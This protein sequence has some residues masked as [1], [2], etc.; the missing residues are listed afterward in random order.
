[1]IKE[2]SPH[3]GFESTNLITGWIQH[4]PGFAQVAIL[5]KHL[6]VRNNLNKT[7]TGGLSSYALLTFL[8][9]FMQITKKEGEKSTYS[10]LKDFSDFVTSFD[11][12]S[13]EICLQK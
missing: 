2:V 3:L 10:L 9:T 8:Y 5:L 4:E 7:F 12:I 13:Y 11:E 6:F 1:M